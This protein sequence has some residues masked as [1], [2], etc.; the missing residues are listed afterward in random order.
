LGL[1]ILVLSRGARLGK[2]RPQHLYYFQAMD[3]NEA[4]PKRALD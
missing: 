3:F 1:A 2:A 4:L